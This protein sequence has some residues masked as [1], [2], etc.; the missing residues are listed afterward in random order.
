MQ[1]KPVKV[2]REA[3][4]YLSSHDNVNVHTIY[5][6]ILQCLCIVASYAIITSYS[7]ILLNLFFVIIY[8]FV[9]DN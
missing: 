4:Q 1:S 3:Y 5:Y 9:N 8:K 2:K 6:Y 7:H